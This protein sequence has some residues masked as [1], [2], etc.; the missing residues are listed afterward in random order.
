[1]FSCPTMVQLLYIICSSLRL[2]LRQS[3][4]ARGSRLLV[5]RQPPEQLLPHLVRPGSVVL[6]AGQACSEELRAERRVALALQ[7]VGARLEVLPA[8]GVSD[9]VGVGELARAGVAFGAQFPENFQQFFLPLSRS[10]W[11]ASCHGCTHGMRGCT[12]WPQ[13]RRMPELGSETLN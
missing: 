4:A 8:A 3:I 9:L 12:L 1:M 13:R 2:D 5:R 11:I 7:G 6:V 10:S